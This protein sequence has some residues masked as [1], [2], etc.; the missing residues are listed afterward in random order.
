MVELSN[1]LQVEEYGTEAYLEFGNFK[2]LESC[3]RLSRGDASVKVLDPRFDKE[4]SWKDLHA[5]SDLRLALWCIKPTDSK[6]HKCLQHVVHIIGRPATCLLD[7]GVDF[8][9][10]TAKTIIAAHNLLFAV[11]SKIILPF[12]DAHFR[13]VGD[14]FRGFFS[15]FGYCFESFCE[16]IGRALSIVFLAHFIGPKAG[17]LL[18]YPV[19]NLETGIEETILD[20]NR[21]KF[22]KEKCGWEDVSDEAIKALASQFSWSKFFRDTNLSY[23]ERDGLY[24]VMAEFT[25]RYTIGDVT[26]THFYKLNN[27]VN[28]YTQ[29]PWLERGMQKFLE[30]KVAL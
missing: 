8:T 21:V 11:G 7:Y 23:Q 13:D 30:E 29:N 24:R 2:L 16:A 12:R 15:S 26:V 19:K 20:A 3:I 28:L 18:S 4:Y 6:A 25:R 1:C 27:G 17:N 9:I 10:T 5:C 14:D 22:L